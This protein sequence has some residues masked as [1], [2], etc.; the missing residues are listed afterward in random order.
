MFS[1]TVNKIFIFW[2]LLLAVNFKGLSQTIKNDKEFDTSFLQYKNKLFKTKDFSNLAVQAKKL[3]KDSIAEVLAKEF[4]RK[5][6]IKKPFT[7]TLSPELQDYLAYFPHILQLN[8]GVVKYISLHP[9]EADKQMNKSG[10]SSSLLDYLVSMYIIQPQ[11]KYYENR[12]NIEYSWNKIKEKTTKLYGE[13]RSSRLVRENQIIWYT[14]KKDWNKVIDLTIEKNDIIGLD[15]VGI[16]K[17]RINNMVYDLFFTYSNDANALKKAAGYM[18]IILKNNMNRDTWLD[19]Y[20][21]VLYKLGYRADGIQMEQKALAIAMYKKDRGAIADYEKTIEKMQNKVPTWLMVQQQKPCITDTS[22]KHWSF[23]TSSQLSANGKYAS[24]IIQNE[25]LN[26][27]TTVLTSTDCKWSMRFPLCKN[28]QFSGDGKIAFVLKDNNNLLLIN[29]ESRKIIDSFYCKKYL[30]HNVNGHQWLFYEKPGV[31]N[32]LIIRNLLNG[33]GL[34]FNNVIEKIPIKNR[35]YVLLK[36]KNDGSEQLKL[37]NLNNDQV[38][39]IVKGVITSAYIFDRLGN[40]IAFISTNGQKK[41]I[42]C[43]NIKNNSAIQYLQEIESCIADSMNVD[44][45]D[46]WRF[47][48]DGDQ[49]LF[50][51]MAKKNQTKVS[52][53]VKIWSYEDLY[54]QSQ[55]QFYG[56]EFFHKGENLCALDL[57]TK[58]ITQ[59]LTGHQKLMPNEQVGKMLLIVSS[60]GQVDEIVWNNKARFNYYVLSLV[61]K[62]LTPLEINSSVSM[63]QMTVTP[64]EKYV[65]Y[66][67]SRKLVYISFE[68][69]TGIKKEISKDINQSLQEYNQ[70]LRGTGNII[71]GV[72]G[73]NST[74]KHVIIQGRYDLWDIDPS[75]AQK[76]VNL[77]GGIRDN[78]GII[79]FPTEKGRSY[80]QN[81]KMLI[82]GFDLQTKNQSVCLLNIK[83]YKIIKVWETSDFIVS[84]YRTAMI[85]QAK[86]TGGYLFRLQSTSE[87]PNFFY[88][89]NFKHFTNISNVN[90]EKEYNWFSSELIVYK[91][92]NGRDCEGVLYKP[93]NFDSGFKHPVIFEYYNGISNEFNKY[94]S[95]ELKGDAFNLPLWL[96]KGYMVCRPNIYADSSRGG[97]SALESIEAAANYLSA[98]NWIDSTKMG[99]TGHSFGGW[100]TNYVVTHS[101]R[102]AAAISLA[103]ISNMTSAYSE[104]WAN[105]GFT[106][107][108]YY[109]NGPYFMIKGLSEDVNLYMENSPSFFVSNIIT[110]LLIIHNEDDDAV[111]V[112]HAYQLFIELRRHGKPGW[113]VQYK[114]ENHIILKEKNLLDVQS[115]TIEFYDYYLN[116]KPKPAWM[117]S[118]TY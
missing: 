6:L 27:S 74:N 79:Y 18:E 64:D 19:T 47:S 46:A 42:W 83:D 41:Y 86:S 26:G 113:L 20:A 107:S 72:A 102:F 2:L 40:K 4:R 65:V 112:V 30:L 99:I 39:N 13:D 35:E 25:P 92:I 110:P 12:N 16:G 106:K 81:D 8:D 66:Y 104:T 17:S 9:A 95:P 91:D 111:P 97:K 101:K 84:P 45:D 89:N 34:Q 24:Y 69:N 52:D 115:K 15:T 70:P 3:G 21:N 114:G 44:T 53:E 36:C 43:Y 50:T 76:P 116:G 77:T 49:L 90:P 87:S 75:N 1:Y 85:G 5:Y 55:Y 82:I 29:T 71:A 33:K 22:Y 105:A 96:A 10:F 80:E 28:I 109:E 59:L 94:I 32:L 103:G 100:I 7:L 56:K 48:P 73:W 31:E 37:L 118:N 11:I 23:V 68:I 51:L 63:E 61:S 108:D 58:K 67:D 78:K 98:F 54:L 88:T 14:Q 57:K 62:K 38:V 117:K 60:F 93:N